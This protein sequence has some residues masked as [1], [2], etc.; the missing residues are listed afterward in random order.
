MVKFLTQFAY[1]IVLPPYWEDREACT[2]KNILN[3]FMVCNICGKSVW[4]LYGRIRN[5][6]PL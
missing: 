6:N 4:S 2:Y 3:L 1:L 5:K